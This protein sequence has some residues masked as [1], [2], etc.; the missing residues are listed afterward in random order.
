V[1]TGWQLAEPGLEL[2]YLLMA[3]DGP[4]ERLLILRLDPALFRFRVR[5]NPGLPWYISEWS[6]V[7]GHRS[8]PVVVV[9]GGYFTPEHLTTGLLV[10][11]GEVFGSP[12]GEF[13]GMFA[14]LPGGRVEVRWLAAQ[15]YDS[16]EM[17]LEAIQSF[18]V[19]VKP[20]GVMGFP[21]DADAGLPSRRTVV[22]QDVEGRILFI[23]APRGY[24]ALH[25]LAI[26]LA[27]S[28]LGIDTAL[29]LDGGQSSGIFVDAG[30]MAV[31]T[32]SLVPVPSVIVVERR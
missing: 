26:F 32:D 1:D 17:L 8:A 10:S 13:A 24:A 15:P 19:L 2:R 12:Y 7:E 3:G 29:N 4:A 23:V 22:A 5:Y 21:A 20:G 9:N 11:D 18:P 27:S 28:D 16:Q 31:H 6:A 14:V 30:E 25:Q